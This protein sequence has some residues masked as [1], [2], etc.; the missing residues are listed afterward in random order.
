VDIKTIITFDDGGVSH[1]PNHI[2]AHF[3]CV[4]FY[5]THV[6]S[7]TRSSFSNIDLYT[8]ETVGMMR[9]YNG[10]LDIFLSRSDQVN[11]YTKSPIPAMYAMTIHHTQWVWYRKLF[12]WFARYVYY[13]G[14]THYPKAL[15]QVD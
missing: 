13:N 9:K 12:L 2:A 15:E 3:G 6:K 5:E 8:L 14:L 11:F 4:K 1:H 7:E 10:F